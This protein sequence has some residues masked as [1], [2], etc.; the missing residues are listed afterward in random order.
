[1]IC[2]LAFLALQEVQIEEAWMPYFR[3]LAQ[4]QTAEG[5]WGAK[6]EGCT[7][8]EPVPPPAVEPAK[9]SE[10][11]L[12]LGDDDPGTRDAAERD[13]R[14]LGESALPALRAG[15]D[16]K[17]AEV[18]GRCA[19]LE[20]SLAARC[21]GVSDLE[22]TSLAVLAFLGGGY[23]HLSKDTYDDLCFGAVVKKGLRWLI[24]RQ[25]GDGCFDPKDAVANAVA[26]LALSEAYGQTGS[27]LFKEQAQNAVSA[28]ERS[29]GGHERALA[30]KAWVLI[31]ARNSGLE[32]G[33]SEQAASLAE[34]LKTSRSI[35]GLAGRTRLRLA[36]VRKADP[37]DMEPV[38]AA[39]PGELDPETRLF[40][41][42]ALYSLD[43]P[44]GPRWKTWN[45]R[46]KEA[47]G[48]YPPR[49]VP[50]CERGSREGEGFRGRLR[51]TALTQMSLQI[52][53]Q[54]ANVFGAGK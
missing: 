53:V 13:L 14:G 38:A 37:G 33:H 42:T 8:P 47:L 1:M 28:V 45:P 20:A 51:A 39:L 48:T 52:Y 27:M 43:A 4:H 54:Y 6:P 16:H 31:S 15:T 21:R 5:S 46:F 19:R 49:G 29:H 30:W 32:G 24:A 17:D 23:S 44:S 35:Q 11:L 40:A 12:G 2:L 50:P 26:A 34:A 41:A 18:R 7:C 10:L 9:L 25:D 36:F 22:T 3:Y